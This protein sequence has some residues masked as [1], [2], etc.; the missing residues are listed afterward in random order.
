MRF[1]RRFRTA[2]VALALAG[3]ALNGLAVASGPLALDIQKPGHVLLAEDIQKPGHGLFALDIQKPGHG[4][5]I[6]AQTISRPFG[7][8][9]AEV[10]SISRPLG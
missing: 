6:T 1:P 4:S 10:V 5:V 3:A 8:P 7:D 9:V 2:V